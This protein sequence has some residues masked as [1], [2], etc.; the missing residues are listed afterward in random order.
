MTRFKTALAAAPIIAITWAAF[1]MGSPAPLSA[2]PA[3]APRAVM[4]EWLAANFREAPIALGVTVGGDLVEVLTSR[5][6][7]TWT[8]VVTSTRGRTCLMAAGEGWRVNRPRSG[9]PKA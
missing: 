1:F 7:R 3:C 5:D 4:I 8:I 6:G 9:E 2:Q